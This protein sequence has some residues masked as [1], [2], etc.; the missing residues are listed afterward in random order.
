MSFVPKSLLNGFEGTYEEYVE[1]TSLHRIM[2]GE[3]PSDWKNRIWDRLMY[4]RNNKNYMYSEKDCFYA[5]K[6]KSYLVDGQEYVRECGMAICY[7]CN[8]LVYLGI[9]YLSIG[10]RRVYDGLEGKFITEKFREISFSGAHWG[11]Y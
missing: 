5:Y 6:A 7:S 3:T 4:F 11:M 2:N 1:Y 9:H 8:Q 10:E